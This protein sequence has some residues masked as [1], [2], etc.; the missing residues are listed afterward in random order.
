MPWLIMIIF[1]D[2]I[3]Q[4]SEKNQVDLIVMGTKGASG[5][6]KVIFGSNTVR[7]MQRL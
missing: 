4:L 5:L 3:N 2:S 7:V 6:Q 1:I